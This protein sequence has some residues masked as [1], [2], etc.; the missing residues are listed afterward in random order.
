MGL[1]KYKVQDKSVQVGA[2]LTLEQYAKIIHK[3]KDGF[4]TVATKSVSGEWKERN[5]PVEDWL[6]HIVI[7]EYINCY[8]SMNSFYIPKRNAENARH[9]ENF[10]VDV[11]FYNKGLSKEKVIEMI[12]FLVETA[13]IPMPTL[14]I[15]SGRGLALIWSIESVPGAFLKVRKLYS[16]IEKFLIE[17]LEDLGSDAAA[18]DIPRVLK[19]PFTYDYKTQKKVEVIRYTEQIYTMKFFQDFMNEVNDYNPKIY[20]KKQKKAKILRLFNFYTLAV[21]RAK[22]LEKLCKLRGKNIVGHGNILMHIYSYQQM[23]IHQDYHIMRNKV[24]KQ[25]DTLLYPLE[26]S[27]IESICRDSAR[28]FRDKQKDSKLGY[29]YKTATIIKKL[30]ITAVEQRQLSTLIDKEIKQERNTLKKREVR[31]SVSRK[32]YEKERQDNKKHLLDLLQRHLKKNPKA[33]RKDL[34]EALGVHPTYI[35]K[36]KK[37]LKR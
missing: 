36:L 30:E 10:F 13:R 11:D 6:D 2:G 15:F 29:N 5:Y 17:A 20:E 8:Q 22:D 37:E 33:K 23:L 18:C 35:T 21:A 14:I 1:R 25:N 4:I 12:D 26:K 24:I 34:A 7:N 32:E 28:A 3:E 27:N 16:H 19:V 9:L 31:G